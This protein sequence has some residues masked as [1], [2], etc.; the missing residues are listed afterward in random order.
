VVFHHWED[1]GAADESGAIQVIR[2]GPSLGVLS[3]W[4]AG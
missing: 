1:G 3:F 4:S 2:G